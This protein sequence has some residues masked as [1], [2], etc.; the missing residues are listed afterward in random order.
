MVGGLEL[1]VEMRIPSGR[2]STLLY[3]VISELRSSLSK[4]LNSSVMA[5]CESLFASSKFVSPGTCCV[6]KSQNRSQSN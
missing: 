4:E 1:T 5:A 2:I 3:V 6:I